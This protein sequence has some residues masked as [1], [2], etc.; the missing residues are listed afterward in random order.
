MFH[1]LNKSV[2]Y[3]NMKFFD[4]NPS[5]RIINRV[6]N[7]VVVV[8]DELPWFCHVFMENLS[9]CLG[10]PVAVAIYFPWMLLMMAFVIF[11]LYK[12]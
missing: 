4:E 3:S 11:L 2:I 9:Y 7:D 1:K 6:S 8:D 10:L 5:G 12:V